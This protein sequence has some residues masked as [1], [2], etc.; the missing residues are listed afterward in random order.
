MSDNLIKEYDFAILQS[1][2]I[3]LAERK[4]AEVDGG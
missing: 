3:R 1:D 4:C 2:V